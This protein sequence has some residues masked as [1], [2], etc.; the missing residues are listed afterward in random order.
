MPRKKTIQLPFPISNE[1]AEIPE[2]ILDQDHFVL[3][4]FLLA[5]P[6]EAEEKKATILPLFDEGYPVPRPGL[7]GNSKT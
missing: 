6:P 4:L 5:G 3:A 2:A 1:P 7:D